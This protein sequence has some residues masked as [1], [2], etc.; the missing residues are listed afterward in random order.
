[1]PNSP[2]ATKLAE[3]FSS[4]ALVWMYEK[5]PIEEMVNRDYEGE[6]TQV[7]S[8]L[9]MLTL[10]KVTEKTYSGSP[11]T[12]DSLTEANAILDIN[13]FKSFYYKVKTL[14][15]F[16][17]FIKDPT[18]FVNVQTLNERRK[19]LMTY[20]F[21]FHAD[22]GSGNWYGTD[23]TTGTVTVTTGTG[24]VTGSGTTFTAAMVGKPFKA[25]GHTQ[26]YRVKTY[27]S[28]TSIVIEDDLDDETSVYS[29]GA[30]GA[31]ATYT[32]QANT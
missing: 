30:F 6:I 9:N 21:G 14:D 13:V 10:G 2:Y 31:G 12:A 24:A 23:Y 22:V 19:N 26:W 4:K 1:M 17:S 27:S 25:L 15:M 28:A 5:M 20:L 18:K 32:I 8:R 11:L 3:A 7:G 29:G 16:K